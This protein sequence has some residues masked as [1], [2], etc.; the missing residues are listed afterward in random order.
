MVNTARQIGDAEPSENQPT[1]DRSMSRLVA[2]TAIGVLL[3]LTAQQA[4]AQG[5]SANRPNFAPYWRQP[6][7]PYLNL[8]RGG[9]PAINYYL[10]TIPEQER[11]ANFGF[12]STELQELDNRT[13]NAARGLSLV[14]PILPGGPEKVTGA[15]P[16]YGT[17]GPYYGNTAGY[18]GDNGPRFGVVQPPR[19]GEPVTR[20]RQ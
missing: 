8:A 18:Y 12:L 10:G 9:S 14:E 16:V 1:G 13:L 4:S 19:I 11:R 15:R 3:L 5:M 17:T 2:I 20:K 6:L 7:T